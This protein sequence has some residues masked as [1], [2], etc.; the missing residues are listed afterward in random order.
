MPLTVDQLEQEA[1]QLPA[2]YRAHLAEKLVESL[3][4]A[5]TEEIR[6]L[7]AAEANRRREEIRSG[8]VQPI[9]GE[10]V[11]QKIRRLLGK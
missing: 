2:A 5:D 1:M 7:W 8:A 9:P 4:L 6:Q 3:E 11:I 10:Q